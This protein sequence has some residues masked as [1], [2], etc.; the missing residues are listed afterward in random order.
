MRQGEG[1]GGN[2]DSD[3]GGGG[4]EGMEEEMRERGTKGGRGI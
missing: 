3:G 1:G 4:S 2:G